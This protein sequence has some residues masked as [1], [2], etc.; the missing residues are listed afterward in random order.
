MELD[1]NGAIMDLHTT[2]SISK[3]MR[4]Q[5]PTYVNVNCWNDEIINGMQ[6]AH[7]IMHF[8]IIA[9]SSWIMKLLLRKSINMLY[10]TTIS[11]VH[12]WDSYLAFFM[13]C[14]IAKTLDIANL[15]KTTR[16]LVN[17]HVG[18]KA[19]NTWFLVYLTS[20]LVGYIFSWSS[21]SWWC[22]YVYLGETLI[23]PIDDKYLVVHHV[24]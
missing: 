15:N 6:Y 2:T 4:L 3:K 11:I 14:T 20:P 17:V 22:S 8:L 7:N 1:S 19:S 13:S 12:T 5:P 23:F 24:F 16:N 18:D 21:E 10:V 9:N